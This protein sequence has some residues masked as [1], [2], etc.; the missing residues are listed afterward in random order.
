[1][2]VLT[3]DTPWHMYL[4]LQMLVDCVVGYIFLHWDDL[5]VEKRVHYFS[6][7]PHVLVAKQAFCFSSDCVW[8]CLYPEVLLVGKN[9]IWKTLFRQ[10]LFLRAMIPRNITEIF[11]RQSASFNCSPSAV[12]LVISI[13]WVDGPWN[14]VGGKGVWWWRWWYCF[15]FWPN[16]TTMFASLFFPVA[17]SNISYIKRTSFF[18]FW[19]MISFYFY[20]L[21]PKKPWPWR[22]S[23]C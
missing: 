4:L 22:K 8:K 10:Y 12:F 9:V 17:L 16:Q 5:G 11:S 23:V 2:L 21:I 7:R 14:E 6:F 3:Q 1:M 20:I 19:K 15:A 13:C 18:R